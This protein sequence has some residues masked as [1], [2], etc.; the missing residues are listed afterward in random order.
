MIDAADDVAVPSGGRTACLVLAR[1][2]NAL[3]FLFTSTYRVLTRE[4]FGYVYDLS[5]LRP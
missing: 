2:V 1:S 5:V 3:Y 4:R